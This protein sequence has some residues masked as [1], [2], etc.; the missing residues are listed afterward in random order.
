LSIRERTL[1]EIVRIIKPYG[2]IVIVDFSSTKKI[3]G[4]FLINYFIKLFE[5][6]FYS[7]FINSNFYDLLR[8][9]GIEII[10]EIPL[11]SGAVK[12]L[13]GI[14]KIPNH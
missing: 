4:R 14:K 6:K 10:E 11:I 2:P 7:S 5:G 9:A 3:F 13:K 12:I 1:K 8:K